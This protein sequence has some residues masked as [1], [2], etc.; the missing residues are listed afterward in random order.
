MNNCGFLL[1]D[2]PEG[3]TSFQV[4]SCLRKITSIKRIGHTGTLDPFATGLLPICIGPATRLA[5]FVSSASKTY[6]ATI[7]LGIKTDTGDLTGE[8]IFTKPA[9]KLSPE[10]IQNTVKSIL[11]LKEQTPPQY[12]AI[13]VN[14]KRAYELARK[15]AEVELKPRP[16]TVHDF[17][18]IDK[19]GSTLTYQAT[20]SKGTYIRTLSEQFA[21]LTG[22]I[23]TTIALRR[24]AVDK[25]SIDDAVEL[26]EL[27]TDNWLD[28]LISPARILTLPQIKIDD[29]TS[30]KFMNGRFI[31]SSDIAHDQYLVIRQSTMRVLG[32]ARPI[33]DNRLKPEIV[34]PE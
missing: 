31:T 33:D 17:M 11:A 23:A 1:I 25:L 30:T 9:E 8:T 5:S 6:L 26:A 29:E 19:D 21:E 22:N 14:G 24:I 18:I 3:I 27:T 15:G 32:I 4:I 10:I 2:K 12:S 16:I 20:V 34:L 28:H 7:K 13:K